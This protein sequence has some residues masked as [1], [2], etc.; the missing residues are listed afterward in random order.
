MHIAF[1][2][3]FLK[4]FVQAKL[5]WKWNTEF[6]YAGTTNMGTIANRQN[7]FR[8]CLSP[9]IFI[10]YIKNNK[11]QKQENVQKKNNEYEKK[12]F[13]VHVASK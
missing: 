3:I 4:I 5:N 2:I 7:I 1:K 12:Y 6:Q 13:Q 11:M 10:N 9:L 8:K